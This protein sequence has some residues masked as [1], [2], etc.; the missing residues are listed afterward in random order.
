MSLKRLSGLGACRIRW[1][2]RLKGL[3]MTGKLIGARREQ[4][5]E[6]AIPVVIIT[7]VEEG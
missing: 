7:C 4:G 1:D 3:S 5:P 2:H 6:R